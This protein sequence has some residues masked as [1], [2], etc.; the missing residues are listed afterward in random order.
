MSTARK[1]AASGKKG[2]PATDDRLVLAGPPGRLT[3]VFSVANS[4]D[5]TLPIDGVRVRRPKQPEVSGTAGAVLA[6]G[7][8]APVPVRVTLA[9]DTPPGEYPAEVEVAGTVRAVTLRV[10]ARLAVTVSPPS[11]V[12]APGTEQVTLDLSNTGNVALPLAALTRART[13]DG[14]PDPGPDVVLRIADPP[15]VEPG[16]RVTVPAALEIPDLDPARR[17][18]ASVPIGLSSLDIHVLPRTLPEETP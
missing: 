12:A 3:G 4:G 16:Q 8:T 9:P 15:T 11:V 7:E 1:K 13:D 18:T 10:E 5:R 6:P 2:A 17:H 14:G